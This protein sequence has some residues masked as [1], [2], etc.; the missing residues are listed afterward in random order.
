[1]YRARL[2]H[3]D[4]LRAI[5]GLGKGQSLRVSN[6]A[7]RAVQI[8]AVLACLIAGS[9]I[10]WSNFGSGGLEDYYRPAFA[11]AIAGLAVGIVVA[12]IL[13]LVLGRRR[14]AIDEQQTHKA[15]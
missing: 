3:A 1:M 11:G 13:G 9:I 4:T 10:G 5:A 14:G 6:H 2:A 15:K 12:A 7:C 8:V